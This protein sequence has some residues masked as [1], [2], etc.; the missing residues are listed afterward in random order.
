MRLAWQKAAPSEVLRRA[1]LRTS[2][3]MINSAAMPVLELAKRKMELLERGV[4]RDGG[5]EI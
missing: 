1:G 3:E 2:F 5:V 4:R